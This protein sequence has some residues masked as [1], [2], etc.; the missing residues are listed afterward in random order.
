MHEV[1]Q[2]NVYRAGKQFHSFKKVLRELQEE[3]FERYK[4]RKTTVFRR[5]STCFEPRKG[6]DRG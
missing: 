3:D 6:L 5:F 1:Y 2:E 4:A